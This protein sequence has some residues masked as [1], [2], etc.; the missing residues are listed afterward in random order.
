[1]RV[2]VR[3][4]KWM[5]AP[6]SPWVGSPFVTFVDETGTRKEARRPIGIWLD[7]ETRIAGAPRRVALQT[8]RDSGRLPSNP[9][10]PL[11]A[12]VPYPATWAKF[13]E[14]FKR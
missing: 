10:V 5:Q 14:R 13:A 7:V 2:L 3:F 1:M 12:D 9:T 8:H 4:V 11:T 6:I